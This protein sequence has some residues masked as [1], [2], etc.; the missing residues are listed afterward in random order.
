MAGFCGGL[1]P[2]CLLDFTVGLSGAVVPNAL[3]LCCSICIAASVEIASTAALRNA[4]NLDR[5]SDM[6]GGSSS[7]ES[8]WNNGAKSS[9]KLARLNGFARSVAAPT[10]RNCCRSAVVVLLN[11]AGPLTLLVSFLGCNGLLFLR[12]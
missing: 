5:H 1:Y 12:K 7:T 9:A 6:P 8:P 11:G 3:F 10:R 2:T 4:S